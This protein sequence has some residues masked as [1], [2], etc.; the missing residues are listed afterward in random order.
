M[1]NHYSFL[2]NIKFL[3][4][5]NIELL[6]LEADEIKKS[7]NELKNNISISEDD[8]RNKANLLNR[9]AEKTKQKIQ[10]E[11]DSLTNKTDEESK[12]KKEEA[13]ALLNSFNDITALYNSIINPSSNPWTQDSRT[14]SSEQTPTENKNIFTKATDWIKTQ[15][16]DM[17]DTKNEKKN[18][19]KIDFV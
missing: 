9:R 2:I 15:R 13:E 14:Q 3:L 1:Y 11:I 18:D 6:K 10:K 5:D 7:L 19:E 4:M 17:L 12:K 8:K 16:N